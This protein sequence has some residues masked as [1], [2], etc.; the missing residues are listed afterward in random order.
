[1]SYNKETVQQDKE[2]IAKKYGI[3]YSEFEKYLSMPPKTYRN[4]PNNKNVIEF[5][6]ALYRKFIG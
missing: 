5:F 6:Y 4:F 3:S 2:Y 1:M